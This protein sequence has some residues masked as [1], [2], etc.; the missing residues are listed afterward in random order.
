MKKKELI[1]CHQ[2]GDAG[3]NLG[4]LTWSYLL[5]G[6]LSEYFQFSAELKWLCKYIRPD[7]EGP[8]VP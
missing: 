4:L 5:D 1:M 7:G 8:P 3:Y 2:C 6:N